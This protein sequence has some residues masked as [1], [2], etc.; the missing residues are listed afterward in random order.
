MD[1]KRKPI[2]FCITLFM[3]LVCVGG[4]TAIYIVAN[5]GREDLALYPSLSPAI[6][7]EHFPTS[8][9]EWKDEYQNET[10]LAFLNAS[11]CI[12]RNYILVSLNTVSI[13]TGSLMLKLHYSFYPCGLFFFCDCRLRRAEEWVWVGGL[14]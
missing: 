7:E 2:C 13:D 10:D 4:L 1:P 14:R 8:G 12:T 6:I 11:L 5:T 3:I 9:I